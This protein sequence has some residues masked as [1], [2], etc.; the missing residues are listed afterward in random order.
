MEGIVKRFGDLTA[1]DHV[2]FE[3][4]KGEIHGLLGENGAGKTTL[5]NIL[6]GLYQPNGG[7]I[8]LD[9]E[10]VVIDSARA[11]IAHGVGMVHQH[12]MLVP[13]LT[14]VENLMLGQPGGKGP[15]LD[16]AAAESRIRELAES[17]GF[18]IDPKAKVWQLSVG[19]Q[20]R[21][22]IV[23][24]LYH[25]AELLILD[26]PTA[27]LTP[28]EAEELFVTLKEL[29]A[30]G[31]SVILIS[32]KLEEIMAITGR[33]T[34]LRDGRRVGSHPT[35]KTSVEE[36]ARE[37]VGREVLFRLHREEQEPGKAVLEVEDL[38]ATDDRGTPALQGISFQ[39]REGEIVGLAGVDGNGQKELAEVLAGVRRAEAGSVRLADRD[40]LNRSPREILEAGMFQVP[41]DRHGMGL[42]MDFNVMRNFILKSY[43]KSPFSR[44]GWVDQGQV[45]AHAGRLMD[46]YDVRGGGADRQVRLFSGGNQQKMVL[47]REIHHEP[48]ILVAAQPTRGLDVGATEYVR[49]KRLELGG[50]G[51]AILLISTELEEI[52]SLS[53]RILALYEGTIMGEFRGGHVDLEQL[54]L[55]MAGVRN[56]SVGG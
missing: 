56:P 9:G 34:I 46:D 5:M 24:A 50:R 11:A 40:V 27:V 25:G 7:R 35:S 45:S 43:Y 41:A 19:E 8:F 21:V 31:R 37:M 15:F 49:T 53:D 48:R 13:T 17:Y 3:V 36:L 16:Q 29:A 33:V 6:Y 18:R 1:N 28:Q 23:K 39:L 44:A 4:D 20:Q 52:L 10:E 55:L 32:H 54:G 42:I 47:A 38:H 30:Q 22:E 14:V 51:A 12:F 2:D 26:E